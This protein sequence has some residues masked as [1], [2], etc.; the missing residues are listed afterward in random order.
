ML[1][2]LAPS[3]RALVYGLLG[4]V[5][6]YLSW[7]DQAASVK[8][9][10]R[11]LVCQP[12]ASL[13]TEGKLVLATEVE[14]GDLPSA[15]L[16][17]IAAGRT[18]HHEI[19]DWVRTEPTRT[20]DRLMELR[21]VERL[22]PV[23]ES[24]TTRRRIHRIS[25]NFL[26]FYLG[27]VERFRPEIE[28]GLGESILGVLEQA[29]DDHMGPVWEAAFRDHVRYLA[30]VG[31][32]G[33]DV[34]A[35]GPFWTD[36]GQTEIDSVAL[37]GRGRRPMLVGEAK[38]TKAISGPRVYGDLH[39]KALRLPGFHDELRYLLCA[40]DTIRDLPEGVLGCT[41]ADMFA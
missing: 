36:D 15:V 17:A 7:W 10:L 33:P 5:P 34:V 22:I 16:H 9:N 13:L 40:R 30:G 35:V 12:A 18:R 2:N 23:T 32:I 29:I 14:H 19:K 20:L 1:P 26:A 24:E 28:R 27:T 3:V 25:D 21:L 39:A 38:W 8:D 11:R 31:E 6:L 41:A 37:V 4:G